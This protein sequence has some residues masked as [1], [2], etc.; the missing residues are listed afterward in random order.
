MSNIPDTQKT[1]EVKIQLYGGQESPSQKGLSRVYMSAENLMNLQLKSGEACYI[2]KSEDGFEKRREAIAWA[3]EKKLPNTVVQATKTFLGMCHFEL[4]NQVKICPG[5]SLTTA[6]S[7]SLEDITPGLGT[8]RI[9][10]IEDEDL[11]YW[12]WHLKD[13]L[14]K[15]PIS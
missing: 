1:L 7:V 10:P 12:E 2:W 6:E 8:D 13:S 3:S 11:I 9:G 15:W 4:N 14:S 5:P